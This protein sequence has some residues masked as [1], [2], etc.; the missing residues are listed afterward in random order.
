MAVSKAGTASGQQNVPN[1]NNNYS[2]ECRTSSLWKTHILLKKKKNACHNLGQRHCFYLTGQLKCRQTLEGHS[3]LWVPSQQPTST[4]SLVS[5]SPWM[6]SPFKPGTSRPS[7]CH[8]MEVPQVRITQQSL[9]KG[10]W[11]VIVHFCCK[12]LRFGLARAAMNKLE[13]LLQPLHFPNRKIKS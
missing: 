13:N 10:P 4:A 6:S 9:V 1:S 12:P 2:H 11:N 8:P 7:C 3:P 5:E